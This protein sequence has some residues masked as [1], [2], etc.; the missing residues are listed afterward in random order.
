MFSFEVIATDPETRARAGRIHTP[1]GTIDTPV[2]M[3]VGTLG[4]VKGLT[5]E[6]L[7]ELGAQII[8]CNTYHLYLRPGHERIAELGGLHRFMSWPRPILTDS[9]GFQVLSL[10]PLRRVSEE[11]VV[12]RSHL[13]GSQHSFTPETALEVQRALG[14]DIAMPLDECTEY[15]AGHERARQSMELTARWLE[16]SKTHWYQSCAFEVPGSKFQVPGSNSE[17]AANLQPETWNLE[18]A[19]FGI[20]QGGTYPDLR[21]ESARRTAEMDLPGYAIGGLSVGEPRSLTWELLEAVEPRLPRLRPRY[22]MGVGLPE[23]LPQYVAMGVDMM[24][25]VLPTRNARNGMLFTSQGRLVIRHSRYA[26]D[27]RPPDERCGCPVCRRYSRAYLRHLFLSGE[28]LSSV[29]NTV[30]NLHFYLDTMRRIR[31]AIVVGTSLK[32]FLM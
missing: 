7:E 24:D 21:A 22:L 8:L 25:C 30:H 14:S 4:T 2:F 11:G 19:L 26:G 10:A 31:Q 12:F 27:S 3:P 1:H 6:M 32:S 9:G 28:L 17:A 5:Q 29:L 20:V 18:P 15:P 16:R 13:D 23:E